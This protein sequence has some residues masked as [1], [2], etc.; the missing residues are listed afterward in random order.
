MNERFGSWGKI[1]RVDLTTRKTSTDLIDEATYR[2]FPG[3]RLLIAKT[4]MTEVLDHAERLTRAL[5]ALAIFDGAFEQL[6]Q[7]PVDESHLSLSVCN[8]ILAEVEAV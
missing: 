1:L 7:Q 3:G 8:R 4:L 6:R 2:R 5:V